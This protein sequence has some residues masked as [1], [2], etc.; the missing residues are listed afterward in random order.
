MLTT[1]EVAKLFQVSAQTVINWL[2]QGRMPFERIGRG[3]RRLTEE[4]VLKYIKDIGISHSALDQT[5]FNKTLK[6]VHAGGNETNDSVAVINKDMIII[7]W[8]EGAVSLTGFDTVDALGKSITDFIQNVEHSDSGIDF[9]LRSDW[10][11]AVLNLEAVHASKQG[12]AI[13]VSLT[14]SKFFSQ[15]NLAGYILAY[16]KK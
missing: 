8:N 16:G 14:A 4:T 6:K 10:N 13:N 3:P 9:M 5:I 11:T 7:A 2:D 1:G 15:G 12:K